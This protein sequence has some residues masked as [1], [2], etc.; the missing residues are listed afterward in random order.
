M[1]LKKYFIFTVVFMFLS[2]QKRLSNKQK[3]IVNLAFSTNNNGIKLLYIS[4]FSLLENSNNNTIYNIYIQVKNNFEKELKVLL[5]N[6]EKTYFNC[7]LHFEKRIYKCIS[8]SFRYFYI[9]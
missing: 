6:L 1:N 4:L 8:K 5:H 9:L 7:F 2:N 3:K